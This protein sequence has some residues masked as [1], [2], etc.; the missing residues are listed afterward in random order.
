MRTI[1]EIF[2]EY[3]T[4]L[5][6]QRHMYRVAG[7]AQLII[8]HWNGPVIDRNRIIRVLLLHDIGNIVKVDFDKFPQSLEEEK[9]NVKYWRIVQ[10]EYIEKYGKDDHAVSAAIAKEVGLSPKELKLMDSK[11]FIKNDIIVRS[12][13]YNLKISA[14]ADQRA[15]P[16]S[17]LPILERLLEAKERYKDKPGTSMN[18]P[19]T[20]LLIECAV[21]L[22]KQVV[23]YCNI[24]PQDIT[25]CS[26][27]SEIQKL[28]HFTY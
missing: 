24:K 13:D 14:Y 17:V 12:S 16:N 3:R 27:T 18:N 1:E 22:E 26:I 9:Y 19:K 6:L 2:K 4:P 15:A 7:I 25:D 28:K 11:I 20:D 21:K 10:T 8:N 5:N 23:R